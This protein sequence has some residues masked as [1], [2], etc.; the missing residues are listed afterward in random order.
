MAFA[1][2]LSKL[3]AENIATGKPTMPLDPFNPGRFLGR[4]I[5]WP[6]EYNYTV[7]A[8]FLARL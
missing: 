1:P 6:A 8:E 4:N 3:C 2:I 7:L 5:Q